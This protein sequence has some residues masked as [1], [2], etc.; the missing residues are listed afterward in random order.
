MTLFLFTL[1]NYGWIFLVLLLVAAL[2]TWQAGRRSAR[3]AN[4]GCVSAGILFICV[5]FAFLTF[6]FLSVSLTGSIHSLLTKPRY[7]AQVVSVSG[8]METYTETET[9]SDGRRRSYTRQRMMYTPTVRF[10]DQQGDTVVLETNV[11]SGGAPAVGSTIAVVYSPGDTVLQDISGRGIALLGVGLLFW[12]LSGYGSIAV[13]SY[14]MGRDM[15]GIKK[16]GWLLGRCVIVLM[17]TM[18]LAGLLYGVYG[19][20]SGQTPLPLWAL[21]ICILFSLVLLLT[22]P[23]IIKTFFARQRRVY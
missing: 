23:L 16:A 11:R 20:F 14:A 6:A 15:E 2:A 9:D 5:F 17:T 3:G 12:I 10:V 1:T 18:L 13:V 7:E 19:H 22:L 21:A 8:E 4:F